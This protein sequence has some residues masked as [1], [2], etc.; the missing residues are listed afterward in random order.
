MAT[1]YYDTLG[2]PRNASDK[3]VRNAYR[4]LARTYHPDLN[5]GS[6]KAQERF[7]EASWPWRPP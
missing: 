3:E 5:A 7:K 4:R 2:V 1:S 6:E